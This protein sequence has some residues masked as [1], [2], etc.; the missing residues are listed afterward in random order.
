MLSEIFYWVLNMSILGS[1][2][3]LCVLLLR[4]I[5]ALPRF[6]VYVLW[7]LPLIR[8]WLPFGIA[9][10]YSLLS[11]ISAYA[12]NTVV[13]RKEQPQITAS[14]FVMG[15]DS[16]FPIEY[17]NGLLD[18]VFNV[19]SV[20]WIIICCAT[21]IAAALLYFLTKSELRSAEIIGIN[22]Y[23]SDRITAP[24]VYGIFHPRII[25]PSAIADGDLDY[26]IRHEQVHISRRDNLFRVIAVISACIH[27]FN[28]FSW[29][30]LKFF[31]ID[32]ELAC[33]EKVLRKLG[34][35]QAKEYAHAILTCSSGKTLFASAFGGART[36]VRIEKILSYK[37]LT[38]LS[39]LFF[40]ALVTAVAVIIIT[41]AAL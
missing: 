9:N 17:K 13:V 2:A 25:V 22:I 19:A 39:S 38:V 8:L 37:R 29:L 41:N 33:D 36:K 3:G 35:T 7:I 10:R 21:V 34:K 18:N 31:F 30:F 14:N 27:W 24:A 15:A 11:L 1:T 32:M 26:I 28:P 5:K 16:Y 23:K 40:A 12:T 20:V 6:A 4:R